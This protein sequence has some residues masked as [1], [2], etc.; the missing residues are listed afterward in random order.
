MNFDNTTLIVAGAIF[1][2]VIL[3]L[4]LFLRRPKQR[5]SLSGA[6][7]RPLS[8]TSSARSIDLAEGR[9]VADEGA[10]AAKDVAGQI[11]GVEAHPL[12]APADGPPDNLQTLKGVGPKLAA[13]LN[14]AGFTRFE[15]LARLTP[16]E[17]ALLDERMGAFKGR[18]ARDRVSEQAAYLARG[19]TEGFESAFGK[20]GGA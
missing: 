8:P 18:L 1:A 10:A 12:V 15:Q 11:L 19:D 4:V 7:S 16:N 14:A 20:L 5:V 2:A 17:I 3:L 6:E 9:G 13:Q